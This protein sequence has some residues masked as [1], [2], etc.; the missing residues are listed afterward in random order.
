MSRGL[1]THSVAMEREKK[2]LLEARGV[3]ISNRL[4]QLNALTALLL[5]NRTAEKNE[6]GTESIQHDTPGYDGMIL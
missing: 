2:A 5:L 1:G 3:L 6:D 4:D